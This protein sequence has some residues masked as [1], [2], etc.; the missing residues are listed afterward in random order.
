MAAAD[1]GPCRSEN[2]LEVL[3]VIVDRNPE[4]G[5]KLLVNLLPEVT[6]SISDNVRPS[7]RDWAAGWTGVMTW[8]EYRGFISEL[9]TLVASQC[10]RF[11]C[12]LVGVTRANPRSRSSS[13]CRRRCQHS[14]RHSEPCCGRHA[15]LHLQN[16]IWEKL[17]QLVRD[18]TF[19]HDAHWALPPD[20]VKKFADLRDQIAPQNLIVTIKHLFDDAGLHEGDPTL[21]Y[22]EREAR[23]DFRTGDQLFGNCGLPAAWTR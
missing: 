17:R 2:V 10:G 7:Y 16:A 11:T 13:V 14:G 12:A 15:E 23:R 18:H 6:E 3:N 22:E 19:F 20:E 8:R 9:M 5:W 21:T 1:D 4:I